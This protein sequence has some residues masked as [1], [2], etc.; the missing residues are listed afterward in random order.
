M[1]DDVRS[2]K[3]IA[4]LI[5]L[6]VCAFLGWK[7]YAATLGDDNSHRAVQS[8]IPARVAMKR[9]QSH[10]RRPQTP[11]TNPSQRGAPPVSADVE[12]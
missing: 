2:A 4:I 5:L 3:N 6:F 9:H 12:E 8:P 1:K 11:R 10:R 7:W